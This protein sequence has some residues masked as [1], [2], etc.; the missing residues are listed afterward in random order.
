MLHLIFTIKFLCVGAFIAWS[1]THHKLLF[2][3]ASS[4]PQ[5]PNYCQDSSGQAA[6]M[7]THP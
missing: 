7:E 5:G 2:I 6:Y 3:I 4:T 1:P